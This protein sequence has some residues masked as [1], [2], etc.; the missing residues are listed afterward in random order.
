MSPSPIAD[1]GDALGRILEQGQFGSYAF[2][3]FRYFQSIQPF[4]VQEIPCSDMV[5]VQA[6]V[7]PPGF[8]QANAQPCIWD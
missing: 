2:H 4:L 3:T 5:S 6:S 1:I 7:Y 8:P